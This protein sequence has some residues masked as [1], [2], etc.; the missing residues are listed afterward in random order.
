MGLTE[1][2]GTSADAK[3]FS[4]KS[5]AWYHALKI[6]ENDMQKYTTATHSGCKLQQ[7]QTQPPF[8]TLF[9]TESF[10]VTGKW[11]FFS[12]Q[13]F[14]FRE[15]SSV[16]HFITEILLI[17]GRLCLF[18]FLLFSN[19]TPAGANWVT[20]SLHSYSFICYMQPYCS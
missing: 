20:H 5:E 9:E 15:H 18:L 2:W 11:F 8:P 12:Q 10:K 13:V 17:W 16:W 19:M 14:A 4:W 3:R 6:A 1:S 7:R